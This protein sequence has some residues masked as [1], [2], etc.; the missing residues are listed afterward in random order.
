SRRRRGHRSASRRR[1]WCGCR[2]AG[3]RWV[4]RR[5]RGRGRTCCGRGL[6]GRGLRRRW[7]RPLERARRGRRV[8]RRG[9]G[10]RI[11]GW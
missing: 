2:R 10:A 9:R 11:G 3:G 4:W 1:G 5:R 8:A 7:H 6:C